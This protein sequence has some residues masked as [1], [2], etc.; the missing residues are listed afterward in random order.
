MHHELRTATY[1]WM[2]LLSMF[3]GVADG[4]DPTLCSCSEQPPTSRFYLS[5]SSWGLSLVLKALAWKCWGLNTL[6]GI[7]QPVIAGRQQ[8]ST[9][10]THPHSLGGTILRQ[11][12]SWCLE[13]PRQNWTWAAHG[14]ILLS[15]H[16][17]N[18]LPVVDKEMYC[19][20]PEGVTSSSRC[21]PFRSLASRIV[22]PKLRSLGSPH[23]VT[24][25]GEGQ[26]HGHL[27]LPCKITSM[28][29][30]YSELPARLL[31]FGQAYIMDTTGCPI[32]FFLKMLIP[33]K[34]LAAQTLPRSYF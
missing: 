2:T 15:V 8:R 29:N 34:H 18:V 22:S 13:S 28:G 27:D 25:W 17:I 5:I 10:A 33:K 24:T 14:S 30:I 32:L 12:L 21:Q 6:R 9:V 19:P 26:R 4:V 3:R 11:I 7:S 1:T 16:H 20:D 31:F 23:L